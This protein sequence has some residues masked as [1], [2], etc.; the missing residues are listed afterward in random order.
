MSKI[1][2]KYVVEW[3]ENDKKHKK[4]T[5]W[6]SSTKDAFKEIFKLAKEP[7]EYSISVCHRIKGD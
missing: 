6:Y 2:Y 1:E 4:S 7:G 5:R 3:F